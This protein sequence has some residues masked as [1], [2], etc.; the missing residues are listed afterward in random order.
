MRKLDLPTLK[1]SAAHYLGRYATS[2]AN[3][4][5]VL[6]R[7]V[8]KWCR[9][10]DADP[11]DYAQI[12]SETVSFC[13]EHGLVDDAVF[14]E[15]RTRTL[16]ARG[17]P[18]RRIRLGLAQKGVERGVIDEALEQNEVGDDEA[19]LRFAQR[20]RLGPWRIAGRSEKRDRDIAAMIRAGFSL[21]LA[22]ATVD[23]SDIPDA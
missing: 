22:R 4:E 17:W 2:A 21:D 14:A 7:R 1:K 6:Q 23:R 13:V 10:N 5:K 18:A 16:R 20:R 15:S 11:S 12:V 3:L 9:L 19:A 8:Q